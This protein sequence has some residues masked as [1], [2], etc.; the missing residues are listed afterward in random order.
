[1]N[2]LLPLLLHWLHVYGYPMLWLI[3]FV[4]AVGVPL[5]TSLVLLA[6]GAFAGRD[7][8]NIV[9]LMGI[10]ITAS[11][12]GD[13][14]GYF[15][16]RRWGSGTLQWLGKPRRLHLIPFHTITR[17]RLYFKRKGGW[18]I[19]F[20]RF[21]FSTLGG[22]MNLLAGADHYP[23][24]RFLLYDVTGETLGAVI[25][26]SLGYTFGACWEAGDNLLGAFSG[27]AL[28]LFVVILLAR[29]LVRTLLH[30]RETLAAEPAMSAQKLT[31]DTT[32]PENTPRRITGARRENMG[33]QRQEVLDLEEK[34]EEYKAFLRD[35]QP[36]I[37]PKWLEQIGGL[38]TIDR[39]LIMIDA[40]VTT[41]QAELQQGYNAHT[42]ANYL[43]AVFITV[44]D[45]CVTND[46]RVL[47]IEAEYQRRGG[48][49]L[50]RKHNVV[51]FTA[52][53]FY[54]HMSDKELSADFSGA[55][56]ILVSQVQFRRM[57]HAGLNS[58]KTNA[59]R[60]RSS[61]DNY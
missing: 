26:L 53:G 55:S 3:V 1:M 40:L 24:R 28:V 52:G 46:P 32:P 27:F 7:D 22:V 61:S 43:Y 47:A 45:N 59:Y 49:G 35:F 8:F 16:G 50:N 41:A 11:S 20:S 48:T 12:C 10:T 9:L 18:A 51:F 2:S 33:E 42:L 57:E 4:A 38:A 17:S 29:R 44:G 14:V 60:I 56:H 5:P 58:L 19:F 30:S 36:L 13:N 21:L 39:R 54:E 23:Y 6:A 34:I 15:I 31:V 25:P 37:G